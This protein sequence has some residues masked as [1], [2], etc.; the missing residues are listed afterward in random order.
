MRC[1]PAVILEG[2]LLNYAR[3]RQYTTP[4]T[5]HCGSWASHWIRPRVAVSFERKRSQDASTRGAV[6]CWLPHCLRGEKISI[7]VDSN[8]NVAP[9]VQNFERRS[10]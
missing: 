2:R 1:N 9:F 10:R 5:T 4:T 3:Q 6:A 7:I 8:P